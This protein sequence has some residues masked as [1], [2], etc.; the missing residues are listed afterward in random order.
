M[1][2]LI[3]LTINDKPY[4]MAVEPNKTLTDLLR[5]DLGLTGTKVGCDHGAC[6]A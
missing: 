6:G 4:E 3:N 2:R 5:Y 1:K